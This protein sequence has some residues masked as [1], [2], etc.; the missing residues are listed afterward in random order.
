MDSLSEFAAALG[1]SQ[2]C[3][4]NLVAALK[5]VWDG[6]NWANPLSP[7]GTDLH[8]EV[9]DVLSW[10]LASNYRGHVASE[11][12]FA[13]H[14]LPYWPQKTTSNYTSFDMTDTYLKGYAILNHLNLNRGSHKMQITLV[15]LHN[16]NYSNLYYHKD[17][18]FCVMNFKIL[19][20]L[21]NELLLCCWQ[22]CFE[23]RFAKLITDF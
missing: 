5:R 20:S 7:R 11:P 6:V 12:S 1:S 9:E 14:S 4:Q 16:S 3:Y 21:P 10:D 17:P 23:I 2:T 15:A 8:F 18:S 19:W 22:K 13:S